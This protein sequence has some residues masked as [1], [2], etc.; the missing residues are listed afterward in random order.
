[1]HHD[2]D[3][4]SA[5]ARAHEPAPEFAAI[6]SRQLR[7]IKPVRA[8]LVLALAATV[9]A[10]VLI[11]RPGSGAAT[12]PVPAVAIDLTTPGLSS[13]ALT[14]PLDSLLDVPALAVLETTP[15]LMTGDLP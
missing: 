10:V 1:M 6:R 11:R 7:R 14:M 2:E 9:T 8:V 3:V 4:R 15:N 12:E 5:L 13:T